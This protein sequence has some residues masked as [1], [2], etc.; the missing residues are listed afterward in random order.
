MHSYGLIEQSFFRK[1]HRENL[2][3]PLFSRAI[4]EK[5]IL[6]EGEK[7]FFILDDTGSRGD[8][9][10]I[11]LGKNASLQM[12]RLQCTTGEESLDTKTRICQSEGSTSKV[13]HLTLG[14][15]KVDNRVQVEL[16]ESTADCRLAGILISGEEGFCKQNIRM[17]HR[18]PGC[19]SR[20]LFK[21]VLGGRA[22][23]EFE[24]LILVSRDAQKTQAFQRSDALLLSETA[25]SL[26]LPFLEIY[27]DDVK[28]THGA[29]AGQLDKE[30]L[31]YLQSRGIGKEQARRILI[32]AFA[33]EPLEWIPDPELRTHMENVVSGLLEKI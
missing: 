19:E 31:F 25:R 4:P 26:S 29:T 27:A 3:G 22:Q 24:G 30:A 11:V 10:E 32:S 1:I 15:G 7:A 28:C 16:R 23:S 21:S 6:S 14:P 8:W 5:L 9:T 17:E 18:V 20:Q 2:L 12:L 13:L 33:G